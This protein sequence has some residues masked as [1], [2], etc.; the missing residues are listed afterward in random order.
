MEG[1]VD[2]LG[3]QQ[4]R[5]AGDDV[6]ELV[7]RQ[8]G[9]QRRVRLVGVV[10]DEDDGPILLAPA[11]DQRRRRCARSRGC[12]D[13]PSTG[14]RRPSGRRR[15]AGRARSSLEA[16]HS[17]RTS[18]AATSSRAAAQR[19][20]SR[21]LGV[22]ERRLGDEV[23]GIS[24]TASGRPRRRRRGRRAS[25]RRARSSP[26]GRCAGRGRRRGRRAA[27]RSSPSARGRRRCRSV[28]ERPDRLDGV[29]DLVQDAVDHR[30]GEVG[31]GG[32]EV[33]AEERA[34]R[35]ASQ[36][37]LPKPWSAGTQTGA[38]RGRRQQRRR[39]PA[40]AAGRRSARTSR[41]PRRRSGRSPR[42][43]SW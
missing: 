5:L 24:G 31:A 7:A 19:S 37:G 34:A 16:C 29:G 38:R 18:S 32:A 23:D 28:V 11:L 36:L 10:A 12:R 17:E 6:L 43:R 33:E 25:R 20:R 15:R 30:A 1:R 42:A 26:A 9:P 8:P 39:A 2:R 40:P 27:A 14:P 21:A 35:R 13:G 22:R 41:P 4:V 3:D